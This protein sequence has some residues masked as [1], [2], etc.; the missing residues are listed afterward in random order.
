MIQ[1]YKGRVID[2]DKRVRVYFN[3]HTGLWSI[4]Q[5]GIVVAHADELTLVRC[6][7]SV[8]KPGRERVLREG[9][10]NVHAF[11]TGKLV[12]FTVQVMPPRKLYYNPYKVSSFVDYD[13]MKPVTKPNIVRLNADRSVRYA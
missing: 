2:P 7:T 5:G 3:L 8:S 13:T 9:R 11:I 1:A 6:T 4:Q 10:K 12:T